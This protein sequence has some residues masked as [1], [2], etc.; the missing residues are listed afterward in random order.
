MSRGQG[1]GWCTLVFF[2]FF[3]FDYWKKCILI[4][5]MGSAF[6]LKMQ[7]FISKIR[8]YEGLWKFCSDGQERMEWFRKSFSKILYKYNR[9]SIFN[10]EL[11][12]VK[13]KLCSN[14]MSEQTFWKLPKFLV[15]TEEKKEYILLP[16]IPGT[17][18]HLEVRLCTNRYV[19]LCALLASHLDPFIFNILLWKKIKLT[20]SFCC[21]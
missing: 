2:S 18:V 5:W 15:F 19:F 6:R 8:K 1:L 10:G 17:L 7:N 12:L 3:G 16:V 14:N 20:P 4:N 21:A 13:L 9:L 11:F